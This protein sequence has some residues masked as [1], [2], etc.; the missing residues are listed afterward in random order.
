MNLLDAIKFEP[1]I[2]IIMFSMIFSS[3]GNNNKLL[4]FMLFQAFFFFDILLQRL[5][6]VNLLQDA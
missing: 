1:I 5:D 4:T 6:Y 2:T 3:N